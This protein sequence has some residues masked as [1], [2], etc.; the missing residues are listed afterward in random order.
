MHHRTTISDL[1]L[2]L[3]PQSEMRMTDKRTEGIIMVRKRRTEGPSD[4]ESSEGQEAGSGQGSGAQREPPQQYQ[5]QQGG[6]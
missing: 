3:P 6:G 4:G 2:P 5:Q 1:H